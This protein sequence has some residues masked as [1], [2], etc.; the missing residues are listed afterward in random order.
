[1]E[2]NLID[3]IFNQNT[4]ALK[5]RKTRNRYLNTYDIALEFLSL[6]GGLAIYSIVIKVVINKKKH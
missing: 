4:A 6:I 1:M 2:I 5:V 3:E